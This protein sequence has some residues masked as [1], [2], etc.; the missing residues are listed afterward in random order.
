MCRLFQIRHTGGMGWYEPCRS[1]S[2]VAKHWRSPSLDG[3]EDKAEKAFDNLCDDEPD[4]EVLC[5]REGS[6]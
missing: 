2:E 4:W 1:C 6:D 5:K 3:M